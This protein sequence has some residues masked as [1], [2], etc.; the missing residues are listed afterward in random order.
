[1]PG[2]GFG[3]PVTPSQP[4][5]TTYRL[6]ANGDTSPASHPC[7]QSQPPTAH[8]APWLALAHAS[9]GAGGPCGRADRPG[10]RRR[11]NYLD[12]A[13]D[14]P[15]F[16]VDV[17]DVE[18]LG[19][20]T[21]SPTP[22]GM[23]R[24]R[25]PVAPVGRYP[26]VSSQGHCIRL[27]EASASAPVTTLHHSVLDAISTRIIHVQRRGSSDSPAPK[28]EMRPVMPRALGGTAPR[29]HSCI[30]VSARTHISRLLVPSQLQLSLGWR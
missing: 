6:Q 5:S 27:V 29:D 1:M 9:R 17:D 15:L 7:R 12:A 11:P 4:D 23:R 25:D 21:Q 13:P 10:H 8:A 3:R 2:S 18:A 30:R 16:A 24:R 22:P 28:R 26:R 19:R 20:R 14:A